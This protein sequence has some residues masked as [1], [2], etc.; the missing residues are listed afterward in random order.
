MSSSC[1]MLSAHGLKRAPRRYL[2]DWAFE[3][4]VR[5]ATNGRLDELRFFAPRALDCP[6]RRG[7]A[8]RDAAARFSALPACLA[9]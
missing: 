1:A 4:L 3:G 7:R 6:V 2:R 5:V 8:A 9:S